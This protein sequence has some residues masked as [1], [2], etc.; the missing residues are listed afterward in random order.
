MFP[1]DPFSKPSIISYY[2]NDIFENI[3][4]SFRLFADDT[5]LYIVVDDQVTY[6]LTVNSDPYKSKGLGVLILQY[7]SLFLYLGK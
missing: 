5:S 3:K 7:L 4:S 6:V 2:I 1:K